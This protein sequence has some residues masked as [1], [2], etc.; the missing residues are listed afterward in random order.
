MVLHFRR[1]LTT[2]LGVLLVGLMF[3]LVGCAPTTP[4]ATEGETGGNASDPS[5]LSGSRWELTSFN[6]AGTVQ[7]L[8]PSSVITAEFTDEQVAGSSGCNQYGAAYTLNG[9]S[10]TIEQAMMTEM[11]CL[12]EGFMTQEAT[13]LSALTATTGYTLEGDTLV[14]KYQGGELNFTRVKPVA[15][16]ALEGTP[17]VLNTFV[18]GEAASSLLAGTTITASF[19]AGVVSGMSGCNQYSGSYT[20]EGDQMKVGALAA[21]K[22]A[23]PNEILEQESNFITML[24]TATSFMIEGTRLTITHPDGAL[25]FDSGVTE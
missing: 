22:I 12:E 14:L 9:Q 4:P 10:L 2:P 17:W 7:N 1:K 3:L 19:D 25:I 11:A 6:V 18:M 21:T 16:L 8:L 15:D 5:V 13:Y 24:E 23:C 20:L